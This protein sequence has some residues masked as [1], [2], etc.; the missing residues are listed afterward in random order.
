LSWCLQRLEVQE[1]PISVDVAEVVN[2]AAAAG[3]YKGLASLVAH[4]QEVALIVSSDVAKALW[5]P[6]A[7]QF[8]PS[9]PRG[10]VNVS[11]MPPGVGSLFDGWKEKIPKEFKKKVL[12]DLASGRKLLAS[13]RHPGGFID[14]MEWYL[15]EWGDDDEIV[16]STMVAWATGVDKARSA[17]AFKGLLR[18]YRGDLTPVLK[19]VL[20]SAVE[21]PQS[22][23][24]LVKLL[25][26]L[27]ADGFRV[28]I[29]EEAMTT[30]VGHEPWAVDLVKLLFDHYKD[31]VLI[32]TNVVGEGRAQENEK[33]AWRIFKLVVER[34]G[35]RIWR[36]EELI[37]AELK[38]RDS[39]RAMWARAKAS[40]VGS[41]DLPGSVE[42]VEV[43]KCSATENEAPGEWF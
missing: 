1:Q 32:T 30:A 9:H 42:Q 25:L 29:S 10:W 12:E 39:L 14:L 16:A 36:M 4:F 40:D 26:D 3:N 13:G 6:E 41:A 28:P 38:G 43:A 23:F 35:D 21:T 5:H 34:C 24:G 2:T 19:K 22:S 18:R 7:K 15:Q 27:D 31:Q 17:E 33:E 37:E 20:A 8:W 11:W